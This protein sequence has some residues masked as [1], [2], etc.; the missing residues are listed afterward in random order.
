MSSVNVGVQRIIKSESPIAINVLC[1]GHCLNLV[2][3]HSCSLINLQNA[4][5][6]M[7]M[8]CLFF[9]SSSNIYGLLA[10]FLENPGLPASK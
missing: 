6:K 7:K 2:I 4:I 1:S 10:S 8:I 3:A 9:L 5:D